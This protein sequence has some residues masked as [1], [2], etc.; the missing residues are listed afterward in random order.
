MKAEDLKVGVHIYEVLVFP[1]TNGRIESPVSAYRVAKGPYE[2]GSLRALSV[3]LV[4][5]NPVTGKDEETVTRS[6]YDYNVGRLNDYNLHQFFTDEAEAN[7][8]SQRMEYRL[9][10][11]REIGI[12]NRTL[13]KIQERE[14]Y[15]SW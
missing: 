5:V 3:D 1:Q 13:I 2:E 15:K 11:P 8:Y 7:Y 10:S 9:L 4:R 12:F 14:T 6:L